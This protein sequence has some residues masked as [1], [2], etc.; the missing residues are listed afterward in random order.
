MSEPS[1]M[2]SRSEDF[3]ADVSGSTPPPLESSSDSPESAH[4]FPCEGCGADLEFS[5]GVQNLK[6]PYCGFVKVLEFD[7]ERHVAEQDYYQMLA[8][9]ASW[10]EEGTDQTDGLSEVRCVSCGAKVQFQGTLTS[11][12]CAYCGVPLQLDD[13]HDAADRVPVDG[14]LPFKVDRK[15]AHT[16]LAAWVKSRWFAP[17]RFKKVGVNG[18]FSGVYTPYWTFDTMTTTQYTGQRGDHYWVTVGSGKNRRQVMRTRW[19]YA[20]GT[21]RKFFDDELIV[22]G[23]GLPVKRLNALM[24]WPLEDC[25]PFNQEML[26]GFLARTYDVEL[27][28]GFLIAKGNFEKALVANAKSLIGGDAQRIHSIETQYNAITYKHLLLPVWMMGYRYANK[29]YQVVVNAA[30]AEVQ[31]DRPYSAVKIAFAVVC[32]LVVAGGIA[33]VASSR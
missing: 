18:K 11:S 20:A 15:K 19:S 10:R 17:N 29:A 33:Y 16:A 9:I 1:S 28:Q 2:P 30:T 13:V 25:V 32:G 14:V 5:I 12:E 4:V 26:A 22:G 3:P 23:E 7:P 31:G 27:E 6:C 24:P 8:N 21:F